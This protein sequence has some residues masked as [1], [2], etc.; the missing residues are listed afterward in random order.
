[1]LFEIV[2]LTYQCNLADTSP[3]SYRDCSVLEKG[4]RLHLE[5]TAKKLETR[6]LPW[7][8][9]TSKKY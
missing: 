3:D 1:M 7:I 5:G 9:E 2:K 4:N 6:F 8:K